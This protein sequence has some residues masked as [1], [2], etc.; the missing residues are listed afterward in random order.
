MPLALAFLGHDILRNRHHEAAHRQAPSPNPA[1][2]QPPI[3]AGYADR[4]LGR[5]PAKFALLAF[6]SK[7]SSLT[8]N[9]V[10]G[11][12]WMPQHV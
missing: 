1:L 3:I 9:P 7:T 11:A 10:A 8:S 6:P 4:Y 12:F 5:Q 2:G